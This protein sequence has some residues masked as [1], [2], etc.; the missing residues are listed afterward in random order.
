MPPQELLA[1]C[2]VYIA[3]PDDEATAC[4]FTTSA[5][6]DRLIVVLQGRL[7]ITCGSEGF[8]SDR[9]PWTVLGAAALRRRDFRAD[10]TARV[11][12]PCR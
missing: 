9:G 2:E 1:A 5:P 3:E 12:E 10:F 7:H 8:E 11:M 6:A 4:P